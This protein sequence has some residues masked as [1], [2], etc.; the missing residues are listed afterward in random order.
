MDVA[1]QHR[2]VERN[3]DRAGLIASVATAYRAEFQTSPRVVAAAPGRVNLIG[4]HTDYNDGFVL[5]VAID[6]HIAVAAGPRTDGCLAVHSVLHDSVVTAPLSL[7]RPGREGAWSNYVKGV[8]HLLIQHGVHFSGA[9]LSIVGA[10]PPEAGLSSS[11]ALE[12]ATCGALLALAGTTLSV[13]EQ[14]ELCQQAE[15]DFAGVQCGIMDQF[16]SALG[17]RGHAMFLD[18][19]SLETRHVPIPAGIDL[20]VCHTGIRRP[21]MVS[22]YNTRRAE[23]RRALQECSSLPAPPAS[24]RDLSQES[25]A[26]IIPA[27][28]TLS[29]KRAKHV[30]T[31]N[32]RV[33]QA[34]AALEHNDLSE[35][36]KL[37]YQSHLSLKNDYEV[38]CTE[39]D[40]MVDICAEGEGVYGA[41]MTGAGFGGSAICLVAQESTDELVERLER[42]Y[43]KMTAHTP[44]ILRCAPEDGATA[45]MF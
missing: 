17:R 28:T 25:L 2:E 21:L 5:P 33:L 12:L 29:A 43:P 27:M 3:Y 11:A 4:E 13:R 18:C 38:S 26:G 36:G 9:N 23:C 45:A 15:H 16:A 1:S 7:D 19:R 40:A 30:V 44:L 31:E 20:I 22:A 34:V 14:I 42:E 35:F 10:I 41:R 24:L 32:A 8:A 37:M 39:L 6:R